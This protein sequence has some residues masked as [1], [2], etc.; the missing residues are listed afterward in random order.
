MF[1]LIRSGESIISLLELSQLDEL[2]SIQ[3]YLAQAHP[4]SSQKQATL[5]S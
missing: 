2:M 4:Q 3:Q 5:S 1:L